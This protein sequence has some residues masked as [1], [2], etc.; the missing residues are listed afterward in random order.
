ML[1][2]HLIDEVS[3]LIEHVLLIDAGQIIVDQDADTLRGQ[4]VTV[5]GPSSAVD[6]FTANSDELHRERMGSF[7]RS[8]IR[9]TFGPTE[10][11]HAKS[12]GLEVEPVSLQQLI[13]RLT[14]HTATDTPDARAT[15]EE[16]VR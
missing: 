5:S 16:V 1:S 7:A 13:V 12:L 8:T 9:G 4:V 3:E 6:E 2:T 10:R 11:T 15:R 14:Q